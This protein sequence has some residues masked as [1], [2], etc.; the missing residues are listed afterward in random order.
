MN[1][2]E[3]KNAAFAKAMQIMSS[4]EERAKFE[5][6]S[7]I[8]IEK[9]GQQQSREELLAKHNKGLAQVRKHEAEARR[10]NLL[11]KHGTNTGIG[12]AKPSS[13]PAAE[14]AALAPVHIST[15]S[16]GT[17]HTR[18][19]LRGTLIVEPIQFTSL[20]TILEDELGDVGKVGKQTPKYCF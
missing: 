2:E 15:L 18:R 20:Q 8:E 9:F 6:E 19:V 16:I 3:L 12:G 17:T 5:A 4:P 7:G 11:V 14:L 10:T 13:L 1:P